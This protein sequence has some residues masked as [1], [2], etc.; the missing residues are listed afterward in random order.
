[1]YNVYKTK[2]LIEKLNKEDQD[3]NPDFEKHQIHVKKHF[4]VAAGT[5]LGK[6]NA[7][8]NLI[9]VLKGAWSHVYVYTADPNEKLYLHL[10]SKLK[11]IK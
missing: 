1:M 11:K 2:G 6:T 4:M 9:S 10:Q 7:I 3:W 5:S 8:I